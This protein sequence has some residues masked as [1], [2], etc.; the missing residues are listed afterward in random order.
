MLEIQEILYFPDKNRNCIL[1]L[2]LYLRTFVFSMMIKIHVQG[3]LKTITER[4]F[5]GTYYHSLTRHAAEKYRL[6]S[7][8][9]TS[10]EKEEATFNKIKVYKNLTTNHHP[11][12]L[13]L[14]AVIQSQINEEFSQK[15]ISKENMSHIYHPIK[16]SFSNTIIPFDWIEKYAFQYQSMMKRIADKVWWEENTNGVVLYDIGNN[17]HEKKSI[18]LD[19][20]HRKKRA[21]T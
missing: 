9:S 8:H 18:T 21:N 19:L 16:E 5:F 14:N 13:I 4:K 7:G 2:R 20:Q 11:E 15:S 12:N 3:K 17:D 10:K 6:F 1:I